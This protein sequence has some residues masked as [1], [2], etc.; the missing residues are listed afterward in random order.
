MVRK[1]LLCNTSLTYDFEHLK[2]SRL[3]SFNLCN[4]CNNARS[5]VLVC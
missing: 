2:S 1:V 5:R 3:L 4:D